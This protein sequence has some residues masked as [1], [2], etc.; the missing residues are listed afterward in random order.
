MKD[1]QTDDYTVADGNYGKF[2]GSVTGAKAA[3]GYVQISEADGVSYHKVD[4]AVKTVSVR[5]GNAGLYYT[6]QY[7]YDEVVAR[8]L[9]ANGV[10]LSTQ[11]YVPVADDSDETSLY[12]TGGTSV[13]LTDILK[14]ENTVNTN[15]NNARQRVY[16]RANLKFT[17]GS[18]LYSDVVSASLKDVVETVDA[19]YWDNLSETQKTAL[20]QMFATYADVMAGWMIENLKAQ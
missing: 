7:R 9:S 10:V 16:G 19:K 11:N 12:T 15:K 2:T 5:P 3:E 1:S 18:I 14:T 13:L 6:A 17:D 20:K 4:L 8:N